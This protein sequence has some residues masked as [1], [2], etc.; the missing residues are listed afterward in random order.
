MDENFITKLNPQQKEA[1]KKTKGPSIILAGAGSGKTRVLV[2][3]VIYLIKNHKI[4]PSNILMITFTNK[5]AKEMKNRINLNL[6][7]EKKLGF[8]GTFHSMCARILR[9]DGSYLG[10]DKRYVIYDESDQLKVV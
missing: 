2:A 5:A 10:I 1:V 4:N 9:I 7:S 6:K 8:I 3:K